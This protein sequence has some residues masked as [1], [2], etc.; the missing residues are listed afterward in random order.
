V[1][2]SVEVE[3]RARFAVVDVGDRSVTLSP[4]VPLR[5]GERLA[6]RLTYREGFPSS[7]VFLLTGRGGRSPRNLLPS[8]WALALLRAP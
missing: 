8:N 2:E 4:A 1:R 6:L 3:G 7:V 5:P